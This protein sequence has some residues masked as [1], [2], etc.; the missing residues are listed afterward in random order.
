MRG[1]LKTAQRQQIMYVQQ[2]IIKVWSQSDAP[3]KGKSITQCL[4]PSVNRRRQFGWDL[5]KT[6][7]LP[8]K[9]PQSSRPRKACGSLVCTHTEPG[10]ITDITVSTQKPTMFPQ[11]QGW[12]QKC[13]RWPVLKRKS[14]LTGNNKDR[15]HSPILLKKQTNTNSESHSVGI[16]AGLN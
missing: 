9:T 1:S 10:F 11:E 14:F 7:C 15:K 2:R 16:F 12:E 3:Q 8:R 4:Q 5:R 13:I 6:R